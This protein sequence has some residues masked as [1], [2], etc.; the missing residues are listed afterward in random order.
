LNAK[1]KNL[2]QAD[3]VRNYIAIRLPESKQ[4]LAYDQYWT[5]VEAL[6][7]EKRL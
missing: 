6:L 5:R 2:S 1:G 4:A 3:L 7:Q